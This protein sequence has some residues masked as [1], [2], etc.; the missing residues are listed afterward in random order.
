MFSCCDKK[1]SENDITFQYFHYLCTQIP[2]CS[3]RIEAFLPFQEGGVLRRGLG[4][5]GVMTYKK[6]V[7]CA[8][9]VKRATGKFTLTFV[10][11]LIGCFTLKS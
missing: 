11:L 6:C 7:Y 5:Y 4:R 9:F 10:V 2:F 3:R 1:V 8:Q